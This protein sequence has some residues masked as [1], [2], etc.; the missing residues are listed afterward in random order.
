MGAIKLAEILGEAKKLLEQAQS[1]EAL[2]YLRESA[3]PNKYQNKIISALMF[4]H[5]YLKFKGLVGVLSDE[6]LM[7]ENRK[8]C[9][10]ILSLIDSWLDLSSSEFDSIIEPY[11]RFKKWLVAIGSIFTIIFIFISLTKDCTGLTYKAHFLGSRLKR[12]LV[13][14][15]KSE[16]EAVENEDLDLINQIFSPDAKIIDAETQDSWT[17]NERYRDLFEEFDFELPQ[18]YNIEPSCQC[19]D[20]SSKTSICFTSRS[21]GRYSLESGEI[22]EYP[23]PD[24]DLI[25]EW[26]FT[27]NRDGKWMIQSFRFNVRVT[28][29]K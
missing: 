19:E 17:P 25:S 22:R 13:A 26:L 16:A 20:H 21:K 12:E 18:N 23:A 1:E 14:T 8:L 11:R 10:D 7:A 28:K 2:K 5:N 27:K 3:Q 6:F 9:A 15:I 24:K 29:A 4:Q